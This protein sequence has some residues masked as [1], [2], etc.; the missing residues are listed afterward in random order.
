MVKYIIYSKDLEEGENKWYA[1]LF[2]DWTNPR[3]LCGWVTRDGLIWS[4]RKIGFLKKQ[5][6]YSEREKLY[7]NSRRDC[8][9][10]IR[11]LFTNSRWAYDNG[12]LGLFI[13]EKDKK[14]NGTNSRKINSNS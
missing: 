8:I 1:T 13:G 2:N 12:T 10:T 11:N 3:T 9:R 4:K 5:A 7:F 6:L 14:P